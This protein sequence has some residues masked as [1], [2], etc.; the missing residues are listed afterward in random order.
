MR[1]RSSGDDRRRRRLLDELLVAAL[2]RAVALAEVD[3][4]AVRVGEHLH[5]DVARVLEVAL[6]VDGRVGEVRLRPR[7]APTR[8]PRSASSADAT[9]FMPLPPPPADALIAQRLAELARR[10]RRPRAADPTGSV[11]PGMIGT[12][13][14][15]IARARRGLRAHQLD[16]LG[17]RADP[18]ERPPPRPRA[19]SRRSRRGSRS[20]D[21]RPRRPTRRRGLEQLLDVEVALR[22]GAPGRAAYAS[23][24]RARRGARRGRPRSTPRRS[25]S[26]ARAAR[27]RRGSRSR[28]GS[29]RGLSRTSATGDVFSPKR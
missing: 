18:D 16:R 1:S 14:A 20:P 29:R 7:A 11:V 4:V 3:D 23:S 17:R 24:A 8:T 10:A 13:A 27:G 12:P 21:A 9:T 22:R 26:R 19:R 28:R 15:C 2:D 5:L 25:R 6:D